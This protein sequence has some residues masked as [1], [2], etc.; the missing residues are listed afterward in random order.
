[1]CR[2]KKKVSA[3]QDS[4]RQRRLKAIEDKKKAEREDKRRKPPK[5]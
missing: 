3:G 4:A 5:K 1:M 2:G